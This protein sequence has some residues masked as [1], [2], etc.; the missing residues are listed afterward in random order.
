MRVY[1]ILVIGDTH[2][3][4]RASAVDPRVRSDI[5]SDK[6]YDVVVF[7]GDFT[8]E[9]VVAWVEGLGKD[10]YYVQGNMD[11]LD[12]PKTQKFVLAGIKMGVHHGDGVYPRG[13][14]RQLSRIAKE[15]DVNLLFSGHTHSPFIKLDEENMVLH[16]NPGSLTGVWGGGGGLMVPTYI[17]AYLYDSELEL[18]L[19]ILRGLKIE[20]MKKHVYKWDGSRWILV[21]S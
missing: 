13:N 12:L 21:S 11:Y 7:T 4:D 14:I 3:P 15:L 16:V 1:R 10:V 5:E 8:S 19:F 2:I 9:N 6:P 17:K 20:L 18:R